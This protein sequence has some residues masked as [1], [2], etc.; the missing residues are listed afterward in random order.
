MRRAVA[1]LLAAAVVGGAVGCSD[2][3]PPFCDDLEEIAPLEELSDALG[4]GDLDAAAVEAGE[5]A[6]LAGSAPA[7]IRDQFE[8][9]ADA[10]VDIVDLLESEQA[11]R[12]EGPGTG[13]GSDAPSP[14]GGSGDGGDGGDGDAAVPAEV[15]RLREQLDDRL[16]ELSGDSSEASAWTRE[17][18]GFSLD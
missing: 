2:G 7:E 12:A 1:A 18:C 14:D 15:E 3:R 8:A 16:G 9:L 17:N 4:R 10:L 13:A 11:P 6:D 5:L